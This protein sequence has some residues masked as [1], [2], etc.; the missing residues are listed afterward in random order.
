MMKA[1]PTC[2]DFPRCPVRTV[3]FGEDWQARQQLR[4]LNWRVTFLPSV[5]V[6]RTLCPV[7]A[8]QDVEVRRAG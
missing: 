7:H 6:V 3:V 5:C 8:D 2:C 4:S 1:H